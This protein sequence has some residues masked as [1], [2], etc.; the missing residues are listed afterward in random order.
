MTAPRTADMLL[1][2]PRARPVAPGA[3][4]RPP[5]HLVPDPATLRA[6]RRARLLTAVAALTACFGLFGVV[7]VHVM[8]AQGQGAVQELQARVQEEEDR[9]RRLRLQVAELEAPAEVVAAARDRLGMTAPT[10]VVPLV[11]ASLDHPP[12]TTIPASTAPP[13]SLPQSTS[14]PQSTSPPLTTATP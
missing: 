5:L 2:A 9:H 8:L 1:R 12:P 13:T 10:T 6:R 14:S 7:G 3:D 11:V 4:S